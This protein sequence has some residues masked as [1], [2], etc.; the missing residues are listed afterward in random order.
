MK[1]DKILLIIR[2]VSVI[3]M[4]IVIGINL[5]ITSLRTLPGLV[6]MSVGVI[7]IITSLIELRK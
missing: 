4:M 1:T 3:I 5:L 7:L 6:A 2:I